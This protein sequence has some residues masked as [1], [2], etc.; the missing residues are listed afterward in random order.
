MLP[1]IRT[2]RKATREGL[3]RY[4]PGNGRT[5]FSGFYSITPGPETHGKHD[6][7]ARQAAGFKGSNK[8]AS[9]GERHP[10]PSPHPASEHGYRGVPAEIF[11]KK[12]FAKPVI[13]ALCDVSLSCLHFSA[14]S[15]APGLFFGKIFR[16]VR[17]FAFVG[18]PRR[19]CNPEE[20]TGLQPAHRT[21]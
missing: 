16:Q 3:P 19:S 9:G 6:P 20:R 1:G 12:R 15:L 18:R 13:F 14:F 2:V 10:R 7:P 5:R 4:L 11:V 21:I 8:K 17:C